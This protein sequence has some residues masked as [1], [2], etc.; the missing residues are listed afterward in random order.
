MR[1]EDDVT[2]PATW[3]GIGA[4]AFIVACVAHEA[5]GHG[6]ACVLTGGRIV[7]L[8][9]VLFKCSPANALT[10]ATGPSMNLIVG[11]AAWVAVRYGRI[12]STRLRGLLA[13]I[14]AFDLFWGTGYLIYSSVAGTG[15]WMFALRA[16]AG[17]SAESWTVMMGVLGVFLY[18]RSLR[19]VAAVLPPR[20]PLVAIWLFV[21]LVCC[22]STLFSAGD[23]MLLLREAG[24]ESF[25][26]AVGLLLT[27]RRS[28]E[29]TSTLSTEPL[30]HP[31]WIA[32][33]LASIA[34]FFA[35]LGRGFAGA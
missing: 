19:V 1:D 12:G 30:E 6:G 27:R 14:A 24:S 4:V 21:G 32:L 13:L 18:W 22:A 23:R 25:L 29:S 28:L 16:V 2:G 17:G 15:D 8:T 20:L 10:D 9:S 11:V 34:L 3:L 26:S 5:I 31:A 33:A 35:T 7:L